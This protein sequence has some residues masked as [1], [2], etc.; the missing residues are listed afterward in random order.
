M[1][2]AALILLIT[3]CVLGLTACSS[4]HDMQRSPMSSFAPAEMDAETQ[5]ILQ[6]F[7]TNS[8][9]VARER[10]DVQISSA[11]P[12]DHARKIIRDASMTIEADDAAALYKNL[13]EFNNSMG[14]YEFSAQTHHFD[15]YSTVD[16]VLKVPPHRLDEFMSFAGDNGRIIRSSTTSDDVTDHYFDMKTRVETK[17]RS[18]ESYYVLL[19]NA[20]NLNDILSLQRTI[21][22]IIEEIEAFE[23]RLRVLDNLVEM[24]TVHLYISQKDDPVLEERREIDWSMLT[25]N[26]MGYFIR[27]GFVSVVSVIWTIIQWLVIAVIVTSPIWLITFI[28]L[29]IVFRRAKKKKQAKPAAAAPPIQAIPQDTEPPN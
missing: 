9:V 15:T 6:G 8:D 13:S 20:D 27:T 16:A 11:A 24:A 7:T 19:E 22:G 2:K 12:A 23:G 28:I 21:D 4:G 10:A 29:F 1:K 3:A 26:D 14:G 25:L 18:L 17:R 5:Y